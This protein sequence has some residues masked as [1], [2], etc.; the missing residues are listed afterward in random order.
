MTAYEQGHK[1][2]GRGV[3]RDDNPY[4]W[5]SNDYDAWYDGWMDA[6]G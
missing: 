3:S 1:A 2:Y 4:A 6:R 5:A